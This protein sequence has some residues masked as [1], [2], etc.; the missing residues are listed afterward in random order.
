M[1]KKIIDRLYELI[2]N[3]K[4]NPV[5]NSYT[6]HLFNGGKEEILRK[7][8]E[9]SDEVIQAANNETKDRIISELS[10]LHYHLLVLMAEEGIH[11]ED[12]Y[13]ELEK[14]FNKKKSKD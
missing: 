1:G 12:I 2:L 5:K 6:C 3:R 7:I 14:R 10:D 11:P 8:T 9:E 4:N 13:R